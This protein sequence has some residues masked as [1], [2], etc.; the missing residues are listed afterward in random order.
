MTITFV[1]V[2]IILLSGFYVMYLL[3]VYLSTK[4]KISGIDSRINSL[5]GQEAEEEVKE[6]KRLEREGLRQHN[7]MIQLTGTAPKKSVP[8][9]KTMSSQ[10]EQLLKEFFDGTIVEESK[11]KKRI[12]W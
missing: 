1:K 9:A 7:L 12:G 3:Y 5:E 2:L 8:P 6:R 11:K 10:A 4:K